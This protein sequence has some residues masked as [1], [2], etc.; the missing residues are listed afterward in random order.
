MT[1]IIFFSPSTCG[2]YLPSVHEADIP[3]DVVVVLLREWES[4]L[5]ELANTPQRIAAGPNGQPIL[6]EPAP[7]DT[8]TLAAS[9]VVWRNA[10]LLSSDGLV[11]RHRDELESSAVTTLTAAQYSALQG[12]RRQLRDWPQDD[13]FPLSEHRPQAPIWWLEEVR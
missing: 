6:V 13:D 7:V 4:L 8:A 5:N 1:D 9:E 11:A 3:D 10:Q 12:Y 2:A